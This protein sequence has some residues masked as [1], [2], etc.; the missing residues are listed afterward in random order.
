MSNLKTRYQIQMRR[1]DEHQFHGFSKGFTDK[2]TAINFFEQSV[3][4]REE[5]ESKALDYRIVKV[6]RE[7]IR[8]DNYDGED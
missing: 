6:E 4:N 3:K 8:Q 2:E 5:S 7:V 1:Q